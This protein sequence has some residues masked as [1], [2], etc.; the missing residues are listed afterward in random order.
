MRQH[1]KWVLDSV[2]GSGVPVEWGPRPMDTTTV[3]RESRERAG[4]VRHEQA[5]E[6][7]QWP[8]AIEGN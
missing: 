3:G 2:V 1:A 7:G 8:G 4:R 6:N 5:V